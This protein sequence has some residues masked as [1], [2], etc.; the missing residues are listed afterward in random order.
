ML[1]TELT[2][3]GQPKRPSGIIGGVEVRPQV[4]PHAAPAGTLAFEKI[5]TGTAEVTH[6]PALGLASHRTSCRRK[7]ASRQEA[8]PLQRCSWLP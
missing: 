8:G 1:P 3:A 2:G 4:V 6:L 7:G 5:L